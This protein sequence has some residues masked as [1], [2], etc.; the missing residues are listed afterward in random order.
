MAPDG[1]V[2]QPNGFCLLPNGKAGISAWRP[3]G[4]LR[5]P[6]GTLAGCVAAPPQ[7]RWAQ[8]ASRSIRR[9][10]CLSHTRLLGGPNRPNGLNTVRGGNPMNYCTNHHS[11]VIRLDD[12]NYCII[13]E[14]QAELLGKSI[15]DII[16][17]DRS[18]CE[19][20]VVINH[21]W[22]QTIF[23]V[24]KIAK[25]GHDVPIANQE[26]LDLIGGRP[27]TGINMVAPNPRKASNPYLALIVESERGNIALHVGF[28][29][30]HQFIEA[31]HNERQIPI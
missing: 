28:A 3:V 13:Q 20:E 29:A 11:G 27:I 5:L 9:V 31:V 12:E 26:L 25:V 21:S 4:S 24:A 15:Y 14:F 23:P 2:L 7:G 8:D 30:V 19:V 16:A 22:H 17:P 10:L 1:R 18:L 6:T